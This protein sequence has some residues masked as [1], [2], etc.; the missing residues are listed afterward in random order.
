MALNQIQGGRWDEMLR[1]LFS[2]KQ[3]AVAPT[4]AAELVASIILENDRPE[5]LALLGTRLWAIPL[6]LAGASGV[7]SMGQAFNPVGSG[8]LSIVTSAMVGTRSNFQESGEAYLSDVPLA[9]LSG[10]S[11]KMDTR[12]VPDFAVAANFRS[13]T[14]GRH[15]EGALPAGVQ[16]ISVVTMPFDESHQILQQPVILKPGTGLTVM[17]SGTLRQLTLTLMGYE[18]PLNPSE[19]FDR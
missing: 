14:E 13:S 7:R 16:L 12:L 5:N 1:R 17:V 3:G 8:I 4:V 11:V 19:E 2:M 9:N 6:T 18:R 15:E 10:N